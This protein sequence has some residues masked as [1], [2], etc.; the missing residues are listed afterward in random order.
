MDRDARIWKFARLLIA[1]HG[2]DALEVVH[3]RAQ[4][5]LDKGDHRISSGWARVADIV[6]RMTKTGARRL[7]ADLSD[8]PPLNDVLAGETTNSMM[9]ADRVDR[10]ELDQIITGAKKKLE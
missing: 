1:K 5:R 7:P 4:N 10:Q 8:E 6:K 3:A 2:R 9:K